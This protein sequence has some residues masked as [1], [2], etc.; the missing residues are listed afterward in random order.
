[1]EPKNWLFSGLGLGLGIV[2][3][4]GFVA[5]AEGIWRSPE[6]LGS[7]L[8]SFTAAAI[9]LGGALGA[10]AW[11]EHRLTEREKQTKVIKARSLRDELILYTETMA[12]IAACL[13]YLGKEPNDVVVTVVRNQV[14]ALQIN[15]HAYN[16][17]ASELSGLDSTIALTLPR[18]L[19]SC[20]GVTEAVK[21]FIELAGQQP[22][23]VPKYLPEMARKALSLVCRSIIRLN[24]H[25]PD[26]ASGEKEPEA[27]AKLYLDSGH[28]YVEMLLPAARES[29]EMVRQAQENTRR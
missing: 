12:R 20:E 13:E 9:G 14:D 27:L 15:L 11:S 22:D 18:H 4:L 5:G 17:Y 6:A 10:V 8:G 21:G 2:V 3:T 7:L 29:A 28:A 26:A 16:N 19:R 24:E 23:Y 25:I 1:M